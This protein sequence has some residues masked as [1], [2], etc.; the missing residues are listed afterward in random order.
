MKKSSL[1]LAVIFLIS[2]SFSFQSLN[3]QEKTKVQKEKELR[4]QEAID[5]QKKAMAEQEK[6]QQKAQQE[7]EKTMEDQ[8]VVIDKAMKDAKV[9]I[10]EADI[11]NRMMRVYGNSRGDRS[12]FGNG[13]PFVVSPGMEYYG[14]SFGDS[15]RTSW[16]FSKS[17]KETSFSRD[18]TF[19]VESTVSTVV[20]AVN[21]DCKT[22][23]IRI[24]I[25]MPS[26]KTYSDILIDESG[27]LNW[28]KSFTISDT[29]NKDKTGAWKY[30]ISSSKATGYF[31]ISLQT[32]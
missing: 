20:M 3:A 23:E 11:N 2:M 32:Y 24:K 21:G 16:D 27:N 5:A 18:Y 29:E 7:V 1:I 28:R 12:F 8:Q 31:K 30:E 25:V 15:E 14:H 22:G 17:I 26:G 10:D 13:E 4:M 6:A 19:D 9:K